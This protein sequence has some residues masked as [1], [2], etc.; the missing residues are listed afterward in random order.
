VNRKPVSVIVC[1]RGLLPVVEPLVPI[2][3]SY[4]EAAR[5]LIK[6]D[7]LQITQIGE[8]EIWSDEDGL[9]NKPL[10][11]CVSSPTTDADLAHADQELFEM[12]FVHGDFLIVRWAHLNQE[13]IPVDVLDSDWMHYLKLYEA[14]DIEFARRLNAE[15]FTHET[16]TAPGGN[17]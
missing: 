17:R 7:L 2:N 15:Q 16:P 11:R 3:E 12:H 9:A 14:E 10:N 13:I 1:R 6:C 8:L 4:L 5:K